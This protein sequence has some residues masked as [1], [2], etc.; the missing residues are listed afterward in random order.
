MRQPTR[1]SV[2]LAKSNAINHFKALKFG[3]LYARSV[4]NDAKSGQINDF[5]LNEYLD[6]LVLTETWLC[7]DSHAKQ[8]IGDITCTGHVFHHRPRKTRK[9]GG[10]VYYR[11]T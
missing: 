6:A 2:K 5:T 3:L 9:G 1:T 10:W 11:P 7:P 8:Q 4:G